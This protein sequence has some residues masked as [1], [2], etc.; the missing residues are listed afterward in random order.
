MRALTLP[1]LLATCLAGPM[2]QADGP[3]VSLGFGFNLSQPMG[4]FNTD[5]DSQPGHGFA[6]YMPMD[7]GGGHVLRPK[8]EWTRHNLRT[9][10]DSV[11]RV[12]NGRVYIPDSRRGTTVES[13]GLGFDYLYYFDGNS[14]KRGPYLIAGVGVDFWARERD[15]HDMVSIVTVQPGGGSVTT[16]DY[17]IQK[18]SALTS[19]LGVGM[20]L[21]RGTAVEVKYRNSQYRLTDVALRSSSEAYLTT[22]TRNAGAV[23]VGLTFKF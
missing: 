18:S 1:L 11:V 23:Q 9:Y 12:E 15:D 16:K 5:T 13:H 2:A 7:F 14:R 20:Q 17:A 6:W 22:R 21:S 8:W 3:R 10:A 4:D 19:Q